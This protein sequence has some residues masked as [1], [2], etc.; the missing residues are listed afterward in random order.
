MPGLHLPSLS[1]TGSTRNILYIRR[2]SSLN[3]HGCHGHWS[4]HHSLMWSEHR[5][6]W[7][8]SSHLSSPAPLVI[9]YPPGPQLV[10][11]SMQPLACHSAQQLPELNPVIHTDTTAGI[12]LKPSS[13][14]EPSWL[15]S[16]VHA[17]A[18][19]WPEL[20]LTMSFQVLQLANLMTAV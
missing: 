9:R 2:C 15:S 19:Q 1:T 20:H 5:C 14:P 6:P 18:E 17:P 7:R 12:P 3:W 4:S 8:C 10:Q 11:P 13:A 16:P